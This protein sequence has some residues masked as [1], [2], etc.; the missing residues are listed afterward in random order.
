MIFLIIEK[1]LT[2][3]STKFVRITCTAIYINLLN[4][5]NSQCEGKNHCFS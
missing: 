4:L 2:C 5:P 1:N 3:Y